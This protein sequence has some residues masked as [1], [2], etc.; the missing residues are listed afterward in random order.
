MSRSL[1]RR[2]NAERLVQDLPGAELLEAVDGKDPQQTSGFTTHSGHLHTPAY[3]FSLR[4]AEIGVFAS[5][6]RA[7]QTILDRGWEA[8]LIV[9]DDLAIEP[10]QFARAL[11]LLETHMTP[12]MVVRLPVKDRERPAQICAS[13]GDMKLFLPKTIGLQCICM[14]VG[15]HAAARLLDAS[16]AIDRP[17]DT[18][19]QMHW[20]TNQPIHTLLPTGNRE[21]AGEIGGSTI[22]EKTRASGK[23]ARELKRAAYRAQIAMR[24]QR[25]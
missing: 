10:D 2:P 8:A 18:W 5:H 11:R 21:V 23:L 25:T 15:A 19:L 20:V 3:P 24:P 16:T 4:P 14:V 1:A 6:R 17:V 7:W 9:E 13:D 22:Q 12:D